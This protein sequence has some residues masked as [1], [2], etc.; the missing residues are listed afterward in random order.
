MG[1]RRRY[2]RRATDEIEAPS[3]TQSRI[4]RGLGLDLRIDKQGA[5]AH[6]GLR[7]ALVRP[8]QLFDLALEGL[9]AVGKQLESAAARPVLRGLCIAGLGI[10][11][12]HV[13]Y[14]RLVDARARHQPAER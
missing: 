12:A 5:G 4:V 11:A 13:D 14:D 9:R 8:L 10:A 6:G 3:R 7:E 1:I 2:P